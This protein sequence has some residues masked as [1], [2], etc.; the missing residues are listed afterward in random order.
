VVVAQ[1]AGGRAQEG[2]PDSRWAAGI[3]MMT[4][5]PAVQAELLRGS[6]SA[7]RELAT[8][9]AARIGADPEGLYP[10]LV[11][12]AT[13]AAVQVA[14]EQW[15]HADPPVALTRLLRKAIEQTATLGQPPPPKRRT[16]TRGRSS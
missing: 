6:R 2:P 12:A 11:A 8:V 3:K 14:L 9:I 15:L 4:S 1:F 16:S 10:Q 7:E 13:G 5:E